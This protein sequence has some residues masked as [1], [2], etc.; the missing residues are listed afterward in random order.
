MICKLNILSYLQTKYSPGHTWDTEAMVRWTVVEQSVR[1]PK[2]A[3]L[4]GVI[5]SVHMLKPCSL[6]NQKW[7]SRQQTAGSMGGSGPGPLLKP[8]KM[9]YVLCWSFHDLDW[10]WNGLGHLARRVC[11]DGHPTSS[12]GLLRG[13]SKW[14][15]WPAPKRSFLSSMELVAVHLLCS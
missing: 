9:K 13:Q 4:E 1:G 6:W 3:T 7:L 10:P 2:G 5:R 15:I 11:L 14:P 8:S 12:Q